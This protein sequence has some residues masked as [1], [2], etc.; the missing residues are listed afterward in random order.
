MI[1]DL[2]TFLRIRR[3]HQQSSDRI[4]VHQV[5]GLRDLLQRIEGTPF[6]A[7]R[8]RAAGNRPG[9]LRTVKDL[10][11]FPATSASALAEH[12]A[13]LEASPA[14]LQSCVALDASGRVLA[15]PAGLDART[16]RLHLFAA[17]AAW[18]IGPR[19]RVGMASGEGLGVG[20]EGGMLFAVR[21]ARENDDRRA[22]ARIL[23]PGQ[24]PAV[25][26]A[27]ASPGSANRLVLRGA[28]LPRAML[29]ALGIAEASPPRAILGNALFGPIAWQ[30]GAGALHPIAGRAVLEAVTEEGVAR[31]LTG[32]SRASRAPRTA[33]EL[34]LTLIED[35]GFPIFRVALGLSGRFVSGCACGA[36]TDRIEMEIPFLGPIAVRGGGLLDPLPIV[37]AAAAVPGVQRVALIQESEESARLLVAIAGASAAAAGTAHVV[38]SFHWDAEGG[39]SPAGTR[40]DAGS[41]GSAQDRPVTTPSSSGA[42]TL[43]GATPI[44]APHGP[45][46]PPLGAAP[47]RDAIVAE[48]VGRALG[49]LPLPADLSIVSEIGAETALPFPE[50]GFIRG[51]DAGPLLHVGDLG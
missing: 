45:T 16:R 23:D 3:L 2:V 11:G 34:H 25:V 50:R 47:P 10:L 51:L 36:R 9:D 28:P 19:A 29:G 39:S 27:G 35:S 30:C 7:D 20:E 14:S 37:R 17:L 24:V 48:N 38:Q 13:G 44:P 41:S 40:P 5:L 4:K 8:M 12:L 15:V 33:G 46:Q 43:S 49:A 22:A 32:G 26:A 1:G 18:G 21:R 31:G 6:Y 42:L